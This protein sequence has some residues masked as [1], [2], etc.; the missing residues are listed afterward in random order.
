MVVIIIIVIS[1]LTQTFKNFKFDLLNV[2]DC[3]HNTVTSADRLKKKNQ[4]HYSQN[5]TL[6]IFPYLLLRTCRWNFY[7]GHLYLFVS[8]N[9][10]L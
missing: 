4:P 1:R 5:Q 2:Y 9:I 10:V 7:I 8:F 6:N 3:K